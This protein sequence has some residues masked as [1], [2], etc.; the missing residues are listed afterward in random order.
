MPELPIVNKSG[1]YKFFICNGNNGLMVRSILKQ[2]SWWTSCE[3]DDEGI[4]LYWTQWCKKQFIESLPSKIKEKES[5]SAICCKMCNHMENHFYISNKKALYTYMSQYY[6]A[7]KVD[8]YDTLPFTFLISSGIEDIEFQ[9]FA[10]YFNDLEKLIPKESEDKKS[11]IKNVWIIK[12]G[13]NSNRGNGIEVCK[14]FSE[15][16]K[17]G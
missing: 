9:K 6:H 7:M 5:T 16:K 14:D 4:N 11:K 15:I 10:S 2:R 13:E 17:N 1:Q 8:P 12:P 3:K